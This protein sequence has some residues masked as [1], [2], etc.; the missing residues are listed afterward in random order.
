MSGRELRSEFQRLSAQ[1]AEVLADKGKVHSPESLELLERLGAVAKQ[2]AEKLAEA[3]AQ[4]A[5][6]KRELFGPKADRLSPEQE[7]QLNDLIDDMDAENRRPAPDSDQVLEEDQPERQ[8]NK[9]R[10]LR[11]PLPAEMETETVT[12]EPELGPAHVAARCPC[13]SAKK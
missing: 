13:V 3:E 6:L 2:L 10:R 4:I 12:I 8:R 11:Y 5:E 9:P 7:D 1:I